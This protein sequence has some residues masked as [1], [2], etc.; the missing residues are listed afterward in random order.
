MNPLN[1]WGNPETLSIMIEHISASQ[2][3]ELFFK[4]GFG[5]FMVQFKKFI[6]YY[7]KQIPPFIYLLT[8]PGIYFSFKKNIKI[9][10]QKHQSTKLKRFLIL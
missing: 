7:F 8:I 9:H 1:D 4:Y 2:F 6:G 5:G 3:R 10:P